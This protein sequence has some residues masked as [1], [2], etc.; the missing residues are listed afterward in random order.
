MQNF[1][2]EKMQSYQH[3]PS[4]KFEQNWR[5]NQ[6]QS[7][8]M[9]NDKKTI[10]R[11][12]QNNREDNK[13]DAT[14]KRKFSGYNQSQQSNQNRAT[15][16][17]PCEIDKPTDVIAYET[18]S[19]PIEFIKNSWCFERRNVQTEQK[20]LGLIDMR[21]EDNYISKQNVNHGK[22]FKLKKSFYIEFIHGQI[23]IT[24]YVKVN[25]FS[26]D[27]PFYVVDEQF[28]GNFD[29]VLGM[30]S[31]RKM[32]AQIDFGSSKLIYNSKR[33]E[34]HVYLREANEKKNIQKISV[35]NRN[36]EIKS[37]INI[38]SIKL[39]KNENI[40]E[41][42][43]PEE[44]VQMR[45]LEKIEKEKDICS[46]KSVENEKIVPKE[47]IQNVMIEKVE[48]RD[49]K[50]ENEIKKS[51][52]LKAKNCDVQTV[53]NTKVVLKTQSKVPILRKIIV[54]STF[55]AKS[56]SFFAKP[57]MRKI[58]HK[59]KFK[60]KFAPFLDKFTLKKMWFLRSV[61]KDFKFFEPG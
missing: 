13:F 17:M 35:E 51:K 49:E 16:S 50:I 48:I 29:L 1:K 45:S 40:S 33:V 15:K 5:S 38:C 4:N 52:I 10:Y 39:N 32:S 53:K 37:K 8:A 11:S 27:M 42:I 9:K 58:I 34:T 57:I 7:N 28:M 56:K 41:E 19:I 6:Q 21:T 61:K 44:N 2:Q 3:R 20:L 12:N 14:I 59:S 22:L 30:V 36:E 24:H 54:K 26:Y 55:Q 23:K 31:L 25:L 43:N 18:D 46:K 60:F 47:N